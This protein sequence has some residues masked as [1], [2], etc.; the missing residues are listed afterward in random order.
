MTK[1]LYYSEI[2]EDIC[3]SYIAIGTHCEA[4][5]ACNKIHAKIEY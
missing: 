5:D 3:L 1:Q 2:H 4:D